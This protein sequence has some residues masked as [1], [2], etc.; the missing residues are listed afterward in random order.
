[1]TPQEKVIQKADFIVAAIK[2]GGNLAE[3]EEAYNILAF[4]PSFL[5]QFEVDYKESPF[6]FPVETWKSQLKEK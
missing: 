4:P 1:M 3:A 5:K 6:L 2:L